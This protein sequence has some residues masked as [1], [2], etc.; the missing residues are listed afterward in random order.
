MWVTSHNKYYLRNESYELHK[1]CFDIR[2]KVYSI[3]MAT[4]A[5]NPGGRLPNPF[6]KIDKGAQVLGKKT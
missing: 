2:L 4:Q 3:S 5:R 1:N 6:L